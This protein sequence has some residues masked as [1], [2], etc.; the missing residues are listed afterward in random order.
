MARLQENVPAGWFLATSLGSVPSGFPPSLEP[1][2]GRR[3]GSGPRLLG[4]S[5]LSLAEGAGWPTRSPF[6]R[7]D[8]FRVCVL[9]TPFFRIADTS[10]F[11]SQ[12][13][14]SVASGSEEPE[15]LHPVKELHFE[16][17][18]GKQT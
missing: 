6:V 3:V 7:P 11:G 16:K 1:A 18:P 2:Q 8:F 14:H 4:G 17:V 13:A 5:A 12:I 10:L 15:L 9:C